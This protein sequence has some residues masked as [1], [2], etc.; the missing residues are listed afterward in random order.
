[1]LEEP[2][3]VWAR[4]CWSEADVFTSRIAY[5]EV[6]AA[7]AAAHRSGRLSASGLRDAT[8]RF[9]PIWGDIGV[10]DCGDALMRMAGDAAERHGLRGYDAVHLASAAV[11][12]DAGPLYMLTWDDDLAEA[13]FNAGINGIRIVNA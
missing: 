6:R 1:M 10:A 7:I 4:E 11:I 5:A 12:H 13:A 3:S 9:E 2:G 8:R